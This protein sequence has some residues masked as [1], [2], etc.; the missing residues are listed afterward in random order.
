MILAADE[1]GNAW[2]NL[3]CEFSSIKLNPLLHLIMATSLS[4]VPSDG[5]RE[6]LE[7]VF[8]GDGW[9]VSAW[10]RTLLEAIELWQ[11]LQTWYPASKPLTT[12]SCDLR[13]KCVAEDREMIVM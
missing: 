4:E 10:S 6:A 12:I 5:D 2:T 3:E 8:H 11:S 7:R 13:R 1:V 9:M